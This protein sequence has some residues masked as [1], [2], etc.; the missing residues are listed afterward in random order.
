M[1][2]TNAY[3][4]ENNPVAN[5]LT[6]NYV[7]NTNETI[8]SAA[9]LKHYNEKNNKLRSSDLFNIYSHL[10]LM[11]PIIVI[12]KEEIITLLLKINNVFYNLRFFES[13]ELRS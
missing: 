5:W 7:L 8:T 13:A 11:V 6:E 10:D 9:L 2:D 12:Q 1:D 3:L 4:N